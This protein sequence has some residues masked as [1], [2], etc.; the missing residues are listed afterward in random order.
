MVKQQIAYK[1]CIK[2]EPEQNTVS[3]QSDAQG[4]WEAELLVSESQADDGGAAL[5]EQGAD[6]VE[7]IGMDEFAPQL[8]G[9]APRR[10]A[11]PVGQAML[12]A[13]YWMPRDAGP[14]ADQDLLDA[15]NEV[16]VAPCAGTRIQWMYRVDQDWAHAWKQYF[17]PMR[18]GQRT[19][20]VPSWEQQQ[21]DL[22]ADTITLILDP[23]LA[24]GTGQHATTALCLRVL[25]DLWANDAEAAR[26]ATAPMLDLG[27][28]S[29]ILAIAMAK[30]GCQHITATDNDPVAVRVAQENVERNGVADRI[31]TS[32][33]DLNEL[34]HTYDGIVA[35]ILAVTLVALASQVLRRLQPGGWLVLSGILD[36][37]KDDVW[38]AYRD[39]AAA[40]GR[41]LQWESTALESEWVAMVLRDTTHA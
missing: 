1:G 24:F 10:P 12:V 22:P 20:I 39:A 30:L 41:Q 18:V 38:M 28:G 2:M 5:L 23:G 6:G 8:P 13:S 27:C 16:G 15:L 32:T 26:M 33:A 14:P 17:K 36:S 40:Q 4:W 37:Q 21:T 34:A 25:E 9:S 11:P 19:W 3:E 7:I 35:N 29:G 31:S